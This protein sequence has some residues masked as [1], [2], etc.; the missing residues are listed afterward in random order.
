MNFRI[1]LSGH[2][3]YLNMLVPFFCVL[4]RGCQGSIDPYMSREFSAAEIV[5]PCLQSAGILL[6]KVCILIFSVAVDF[7]YLDI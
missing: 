1:E 6:Q 3:M 7:K 4:S 2:S 5:N